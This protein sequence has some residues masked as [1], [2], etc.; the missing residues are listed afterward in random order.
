MSF[1]AYTVDTTLLLPG[2]SNVSVNI[3]SNMFV[4]AY[5]FRDRFKGG[6]SGVLFAAARSSRATHALTFGSRIHG[7]Y[8]MTSVQH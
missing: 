7:V 1:E 2:V 8:C 3:L 4:R 6:G 5:A